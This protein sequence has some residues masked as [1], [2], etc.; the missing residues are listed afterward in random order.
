MSM[1]ND[2]RK[3]QEKLLIIFDEFIRVCEENNLIYY[4]GG[5]SLIGAVRHKGFIPWDDDMDI[6]MPR[7]DYENLYK[8]WNKVANTDR[9]A[10][11]RTTQNSNYHFRCLGVADKET[12]HIKKYNVNEDIIHA[13]FIDIIPYDGIPNSSIGRIKQIFAAILFSIYNVQR[14]PNF[15]K[16]MVSFITKI[17]LNTIKSPEAR[18]KIWQ[19][20]EKEISKYDLFDTEYCKELTTDKSAL[21]RVLKSSWFTKTK[22]AYFEGRK[23]R[24]P[25]GA[26][27][28]LTSIWGDYMQLPPEKDR[29]PKHD[30]TVFFEDLNN[31]Y[32]KYRG[33]YYLGE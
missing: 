8:I 12:T 15:E 27:E 26:E 22:F 11:F 4:L 30:D 13:L 24:I 19:W 28:Y 29:V 7:R 9:F 5:G 23:V 10:L 14:M 2:I 17:L 33:I 21:T 16:G 6:F 18:Y 31:G 1:N 25:N 3:K 20:A 32:S